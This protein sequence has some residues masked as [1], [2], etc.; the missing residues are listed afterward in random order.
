MKDDAE[1][2]EKCVHKYWCDDFRDQEPCTGEMIPRLA[3][4]VHSHFSPPRSCSHFR[5]CKGSH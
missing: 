1:L 4:F 2:K 3:G 5:H